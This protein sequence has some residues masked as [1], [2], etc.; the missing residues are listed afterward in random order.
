MS[1]AF[2]ERKY[3]LG[4]G[5][6]GDPL[7]YG[8]LSFASNSTSQDKELPI[9]DFVRSYGRSEAAPFLVLNKWVRLA[10]L[11]KLCGL[12]III[13]TYNNTGGDTGFE[14]FMSGESVG[15]RL[16]FMILGISIALFWT[17]YFHCKRNCR[18]PDEQS[19]KLNFWQASLLSAPTSSYL[20]PKR[21]V[22]SSQP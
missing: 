16:L 22:K 21:L 18:F 7:H 20:V 8:I 4:Y 2:G 17:S 12:L 15:V 10:M 13:L 11:A 19:W 1:K 5:Q 6:G 3:I 9:K 14:I